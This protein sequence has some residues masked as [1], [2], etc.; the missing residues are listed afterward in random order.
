MEQT[1]LM[2]EIL[3]IAKVQTYKGRFVVIQCPSEDEMIFMEK[4]LP[5]PCGVSPSV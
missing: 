1:A 3:I 5:Q 2:T 4:S